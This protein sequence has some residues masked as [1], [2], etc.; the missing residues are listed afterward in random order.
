MDALF[1]APMSNVAVVLAVAFGIAVAF[2][3]Y[4]RLRLP[5]LVRMA[6]RNVLRRPVQSLLIIAGLMLATAIISSAFTVGDS[7]T[8]SLKNTAA[9]GS[10]AIEAAFFPNGVETVNVKELIS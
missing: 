6:V 1:G 8:Y 10:G 2:L 5:I 4:I 3:V 7:V 9:D